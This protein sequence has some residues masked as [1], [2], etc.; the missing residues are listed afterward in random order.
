MLEP[1]AGFPSFLR[2]HGNPFMDGPRFVI[3]S[4]ASGLLGC[5]HLLAVGNSAAAVGWPYKSALKLTVAK[6][7]LC[8]RLG[9]GRCTHVLSCNRLGPV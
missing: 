6:S 4:S 9:A 7:L 1:V 3:Y 2:L 8:A 5:F